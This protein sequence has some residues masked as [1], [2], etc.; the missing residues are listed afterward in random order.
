MKPYSKYVAEFLGTFVLSFI[1][2][3]SV[4]TDYPV[5]TPVLAGLTLMIFV[6][7]I[8]HFSGTHINPAVTIALLTRGRINSTEAF[9]YLV[10]QLSAATL[11]MLLFNQTGRGLPVDDAEAGT[12]FLAETLGTMIFAFGIMAVVSG[13]VAK[14]LEG[15]VI[16]G[17]LLLGISLAVVVGSAGL[18]NPA[19]A[20][21]LEFL[22]WQYLLSPVLGA[23]LG[24]ALYELLLGNPIVNVKITK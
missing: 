24:M 4:T 15:V 9:F 8:G 16:G 17:S 7:T 22:S 20:V 14:G 6:Y 1:V 13:K 2:V 12:V 11:A 18:L 21:P 23:I 19:V 10:V 5:A 3:M